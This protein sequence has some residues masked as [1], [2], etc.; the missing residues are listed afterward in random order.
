M[1]GPCAK[2]AAR[3]YV[4]VWRLIRAERDAALRQGAR[5]LRLVPLPVDDE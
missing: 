4:E 1:T 3:R 5:R 2:C